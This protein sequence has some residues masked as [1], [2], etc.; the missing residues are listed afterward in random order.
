M[1]FWPGTF[2][3]TPH[4]PDGKHRGRFLKRPVTTEIPSNGGNCLFR[5]R[6]WENLHPGT[7]M[8]RTPQ[9][10]LKM[11]SWQ[12]LDGEGPHL[13]RKWKT[14]VHKVV[15]H[16]SHIWE[17]LLLEGNLVFPLLL[18]FCFFLVLHCLFQDL[19]NYFHAFSTCKW[20]EILVTILT[21]IVSRAYED[22]REKL[23]EREQP[24]SQN[25]PTSALD[26]V[27]C[28]YHQ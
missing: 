10:S 1:V 9:K 23:G 24:C 28:T 20:P 12:A 3:R 27:S 8:D 26:T 7:F 19:H 18:F 16:I 13:T 15:G 21:V 5:R 17:V 22:C 6:T 11:R 25:F 2:K 14:E 4:P